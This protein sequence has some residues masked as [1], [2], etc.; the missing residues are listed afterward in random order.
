MA[1]GYSGRSGLLGGEGLLP[2]LLMGQ[3]GRG[4]EDLLPLLLLLGQGETETS[5]SSSV[6]SS[7]SEDLP[8]SFAAN[9]QGLVGE[10]VKL[11]LGSSTFVPNPTTII[12]RLAAV[13]SDFVVLTHITLNGTPIVDPRR[14]VIRETLI[15]GIERLSRRQ[16]LL[17]ALY[18]FAC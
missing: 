5:G 3:G 13:G 11:V 8:T 9:L 2:F 6:S 17:E 18:T 12:A 16:L 4:G 14:L 10:R 15:L 1:N 7:G